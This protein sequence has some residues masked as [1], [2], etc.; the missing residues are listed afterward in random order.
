MTDLY[1]LTAVQKTYAGRTVLDVDQLAVQRGE[2]LAI[3]G[4][5]GAGKST[6]LRLLNFL[7]PPSSGIITFD[8]EPIPADPPLALLRRVTTVFQR[9]ILL[10]RSVR[11]NVA[12]GMRLRGLVPDGAVRQA[13]DRVGLAGME[14]VTATTLSGGEQQRVALARALVINRSEER[15]VGKECRL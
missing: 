3:V 14:S 8:S 10:S 12:Y 6:L 2:I 15:R 7:E 9:P 13:L 5:S 4:P 11:Q 1:R